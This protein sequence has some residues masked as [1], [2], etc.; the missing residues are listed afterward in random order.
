[1]VLVLTILQSL[2]PGKETF[3]KP[4]HSTSGIPLKVQFIILGFIILFGLYIYFR[5]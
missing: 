2:N 5:V 3:G 1:M 4:Y